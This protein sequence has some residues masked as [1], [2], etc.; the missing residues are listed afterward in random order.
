M[1]LQ[2]LVTQVPSYWKL[3][4]KNV[5]F[6]A[7]TC[8]L[9]ISFIFLITGSPDVHITNNYGPGAVLNPVL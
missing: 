5:E 4:R 6:N 9:T 8:T 1:T 2:Y 3:D 7:M